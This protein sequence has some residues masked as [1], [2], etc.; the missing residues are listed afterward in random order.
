MIIVY[1]YIGKL[2]EY[3]IYT[4]KQSKLFFKGD[5]YLITDD[6]KSIYLKEL[7]IKIIPYNEVKDEKFENII[8]KNKHKFLIMKELKER[9]LLFI[10]ALERF[11][12]LKNLLKKYELE[13]CFFMEIDNMIYDDPSNWENIF[14]KDNIWFMLDSKDR[15]STGVCY[16]KNYECMESLIQ[17]YNDYIEYNPKKDKILSEM[18]ANFHYYKE[19]NNV[20]FLPIIWNNDKYSKETYLN[21]D[22]FNNSIFDASSIG[23]YLCGFD[24][25]HTGNKLVLN[26]KNKYAEIDYTKYKFIWEDDELGRKIPYILND[27]K[28]IKINNLHIHS[29]ELKLGMSI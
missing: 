28:K 15:I 4:I 9:E 11:Y 17:F 6:I 29:K 5:I 10:R 21:Y 14:L 24:K 1:S 13:N 26:Q 2:P 12:L 7:Y 27:D 18:R 8:E 19:Y 20:H 23:I 3:I 25:I 22:K 16:F